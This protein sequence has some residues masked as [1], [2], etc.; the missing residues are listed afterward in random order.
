MTFQT[1]NS[2]L[3]IFR[4]RQ[5]VSELRDLNFLIVEFFQFGQS[6]PYSSRAA[7]NLD[8]NGGLDY[9][10]MTEEQ[11]YEYFVSITESSN[12]EMSIQVELDKK[13]DHPA[14]EG[15][16]EKLIEYEFKQQSDAAAAVIQD[17][18]QVKCTICQD[19]YKE[20]DMLKEAPCSHN[21]HK[22]CL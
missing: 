5:D 12:F 18:I 2:I 8:L 20:G 21:F 14:K 13:I 3:G 1:L 17:L 15:V 19:E 7:R 10:N 11:R 16:F 22:E 9:D 6:R 4:K